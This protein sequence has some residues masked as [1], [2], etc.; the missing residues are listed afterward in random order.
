MKETR[1]INALS[2]RLLN[3]LTEK[4][5]GS[6][7]EGVNQPIVSSSSDGLQLGENL[8]SEG[9]L[10]AIRILRKKGKALNF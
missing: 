8:L 7:V 9:L 4:S 6:S 2:V 1:E 10:N 3:K 5:S